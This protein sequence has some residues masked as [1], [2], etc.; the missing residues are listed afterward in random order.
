MIREE[1]CITEIFR[2]AFT[3]FRRDRSGCGGGVFICVKNY[4][5][6]AELWV[7][8]DFEMITVEVKGIDPKYT[9]EIIGI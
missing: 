1:I 4:I 7:D 8:E 5:A 6:C 3:T 2:A 9:W